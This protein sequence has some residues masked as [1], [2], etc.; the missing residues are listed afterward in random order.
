MVSGPDPYEAC[1]GR[2][3]EI[4]PTTGDF[5]CEKH[6]PGVAESLLVLIAVLL[7]IIAWRHKSK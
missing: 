6:D 5:I 3:A 1:N 7:A 2:V 4:S